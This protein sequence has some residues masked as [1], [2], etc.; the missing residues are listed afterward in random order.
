MLCT[1][2]AECG[3]TS[4]AYDFLLKEDYP[5][6]LFCVNLGATTI[7]ERWNSVLPDG[8][9]NPDGMNS[10]NHYTYGSIAGWMISYLCGLRPLEPGYRKAIIAPEPDARLGKARAEVHTAAGTF[11][12]G[13]RYAGETPRYEI[14]VPF[15]AT[16]ELLLPGREP[17]TLSAGEYQ[18]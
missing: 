12:S 10:L 5:S 7:W 8:H 9:M 1:V 2:L 16:A 13:W 15:G 4:L 3:L 14:S 17:E 11:V 18:F 6:W